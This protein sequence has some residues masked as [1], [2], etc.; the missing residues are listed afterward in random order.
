VEPAAHVEHLRSEGAALVAAARRRGLRGAVPACPGWSATDLIRHVGGVHGRF[1]LNVERGGDQPV[2]GRDVP[3]ADRPPEG[4]G[5]ALVDWFEH[6][7]EELAR[8]LTRADPDDAVP[9]WAGQRPVRW[10]ARRMA[11]ETAVHRWDLEATDGVAAAI[12]PDLAVDGVDELLEVFAPFVPADRLGQAATMHL[13]ATDPGLSD[14]AGEWMVQL[15]PERITCTHGHGKGDLAVRG[16]A[17]DLLLLLWNRVP[18]DDRYQVFGDRSIVES[19]SAIL[20]V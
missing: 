9:T 4:D 7:L 16:T 8:Q 5:P 13:H 3:A 1:R 15:G 12:D 17:S 2:R 18:A 6:Q 11:Q 14:G 20:A 10:V 19:W